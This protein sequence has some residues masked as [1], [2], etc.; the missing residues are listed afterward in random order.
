MARVL[1]ACW[2]SYGDL[3]PYLAIAHRLRARGHDPVI[4]SCPYYAALVAA[5]GVA[6]RPM[7]PDVRP[8]DTA[9]LAR[10]MDASRGTE[11]ILR[12]LIVPALAESAA[13]LEAAAD[14]V[15]LIV[16]HPVTFAAPLV[17]ERR[18]LPW[19]SSVLAPMSFFSAY[20]F[21]ALPNAPWAVG[22]RRLGPWAGR[23]LMAVARR[24]TAPW[25][26][27]V[28]ALRAEWGLPPAGDP[29][30]EGQFSPLGTL[31]LF[32]TALGPPQRDW[33]A[34]TTVTGFP[35]F[36][37]AIPMSP[38]VDAF[39]E[40]G[41]AP[42]VFTLGSSAVFSPG[43]FYEASA[44]AA[45]SLGKRALLLVGPTPTTSLAGL[46]SDVLVVEGAPHDQV[47]PRAA[48]VVHQG[49]V[50]TTGQAM[51]SGRPQLVVPHAHD[52][53][54]N[55][56]RMR[57]RGV[58]RVVYASRY[59]HTRAAAALSALLRDWAVAAGAGHVGGLV[60]G[61]GGAETAA[62]VID[63]ALAPGSR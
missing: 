5:E 62:D 59:N 11:V 49:G 1:L 6:F 48:A 30:Y 17:A 18:G 26:E 33:P 35:F 40:G 8:D 61:E 60:A 4:A 47:F 36:N 42:I 54:D 37:R 10:L 41:P 44:A 27:P 43:R 52:Q 23:A 38:E 50:G 28:R 57:R 13:D 29:L 46:S 32:S 31:A 3:F 15:D 9:L 21:P 25:T 45:R 22:L 55:A 34:H 20:D 53:F 2:G 39:L 14:G 51:R 58:A 24:I 19:L 63:A 7:R 12:E 16:S 56:A